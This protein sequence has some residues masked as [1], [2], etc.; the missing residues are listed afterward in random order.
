MTQVMKYT[1]ISNKQ[2][3][4]LQGT[5]LKI[6]QQQQRMPQAIITAAKTGKP[7]ASTEHVKPVGCQGKAVGRQQQEVAAAEA[8]RQWLAKLAGMEQLLYS[9]QSAQFLDIR[10]HEA[11]AFKEKLGRD[12]AAQTVKLTETVTA[13]SQN[14][15]D[16]NTKQQQVSSTEAAKEE[17][18]KAAAAALEAV[19]AAVPRHRQDLTLLEALDKALEGTKRLSQK[20]FSESNAAAGVIT[21]DIA[22]LQQLLQPQG[23]RGLERATARKK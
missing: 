4:V 3:S 5:A 14:V 11:E 16:L 8:R 7:P 22:K 12:L 13:S 10:K 17:T 2:S 23:Y 20:R 15:L 1:I 6:Q 18:E 19:L 21:V 9:A